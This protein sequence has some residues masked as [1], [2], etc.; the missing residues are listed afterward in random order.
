MRGEKSEGICIFCSYLPLV[1]I[2]FFLP[3]LAAVFCALHC[4]LFVYVGLQSHG[5]STI[6][7]H[8]AKYCIQSLLVVV[9]WETREGR[10]RIYPKGIPP[11]LLLF[12]F[13][14]FSLI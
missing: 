11:T 3:V 2:R 14:N 8:K 13:L 5:C 7:K 6:Y 12:V 10:I 9:S 4:L 1:F